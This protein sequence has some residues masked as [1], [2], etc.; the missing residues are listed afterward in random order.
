MDLEVPETTWF[1][2]R[3]EDG[4]IEDPSSGESAFASPSP[5]AVLKVTRELTSDLAG[6][7]DRNQVMQAIVQRTRLLLG[8][9]IADISRNDLAAGQTYVCY[10]DGVRNRD[11][12]STRL[13]S[14]HLR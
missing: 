10:S 2:W 12:K 9:D 7:R 3:Q 6:N 13:N 5:A 11:R 14:S 8:A 1:R 4:V